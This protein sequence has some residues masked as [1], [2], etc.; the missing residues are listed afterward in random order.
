MTT[1]DTADRP[2]TP[3]TR[4][5][6]VVI[7]LALIV[8]APLVITG[9]INLHQFQK[10]YKNKVENELSVMIERH[11]FI[12][13][14]F[15]NDRLSDVRVITREHPL[16]RLGDADFLRQVLNIMREEYHGAFVD[17]GLVNQEGTQVAL[18]LIHISEPTRPTT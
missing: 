9:A 4:V 14:S 5:R 8:L 6:S 13:D 11:S 7:G 3:K 18:S 15:I 2:N 16:E 10:V 12:I 17:L 1:S